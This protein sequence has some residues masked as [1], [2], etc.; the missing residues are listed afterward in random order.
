M[1]RLPIIGMFH[2][3]I[4]SLKKTRPR[5]VVITP[6]RV[7]WFGKGKSLSDNAATKVV[8]IFSLTHKGKSRIPYAPNQQKVVLIAFSKIASMLQ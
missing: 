2:I 6:L 4:N 7:L 1:F 5:D 3:W 8:A